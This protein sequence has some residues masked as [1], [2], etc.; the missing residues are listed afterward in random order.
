MAVLKPSLKAFDQVCRSGSFTKASAKLYVTPSAVMQQIDALER[1]YGVRLFH[2]THQGVQ[3]TEAGAYLYEETQ[4]MLQ[5]AEE[6]RTR[7]S[8]IAE[9]SET[10]C[11]GTSILEKCRLLYDLWAL[12]S[13]KHPA[14]RIEM[15]NISAG[16]NIQD[17]AD[18]I[19]SLNSG[20]GWMRE[21]QFLE[22]CRVPIG[23]AMEKAHPLAGKAVIDP[24]D[25]AGQPVGTFQGTTYEGHDS[26]Y[27]Y[28][29]GL[30]AQLLW[31]DMPSPSVFWECA[32]QHRLLLAPLCWSDILAGLTLRPVRWD[33][34]LPYGIFSRQ[35]PR[36]E[37]RRFIRYIEKVYSGE[38]PDDIV[39][40]LNY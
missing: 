5:R 35:H 30:G 38:G 10:V 24:E 31:L 15:V 9:G 3:P 23:I 32:F 29:G 39:P 37:V 12:Y 19:E 7:L 28:L 25:L 22:I 21:W 18:L 17:R 6:V 26:L 4:K 33:Y 1:E 11:I 34:A 13:Q 16:S 2:R 20:I 27:R 40:V 36:D 14:C 8:T